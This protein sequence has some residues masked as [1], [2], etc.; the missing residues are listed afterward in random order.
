MT[1]WLPDLTGKSGPLYLQLADAIEEAIAD[2]SLPTGQKLPPQRNLAFDLKVTIGTIGRAYA[3]AH[4]RGLVTG[5]VGRGTYVLEKHDQKNAS[6][7][8]S[9]DGIAGTRVQDAPLDKGRF[10]TTAAPDVGQQVVIEPLIGSVIRDFPHEIVNYT[11]HFP[12]HWLEAGRRWL[13]Q[14]NAPHDGSNI[15]ITNGAHAGAIAVITAFTSPGDRIVFEDL[16]YTQ[17]SRSVRLTGRRIAIAPSDE[18]G[19]IP[20]EFERVCNQQ[21]PTMAFLMPS[22]HNPTLAI[23][24]Y[25]RRR[26]IAAIAAQHNV[27]LIEDD[28]YGVMT[29]SNI[30]KMADIAPERTFLIGSL[31]KSVSAGLR[32]GWVAC[33]P[34]CAQRVRVTHKLMSGGVSFLLAEAAAQLVLSGEAQTL[35]RKCSAEIEWRENLARQVFAGYDFVSSPHV[36][37]LWLKLPEPWLAGTFKAA[38][39]ENG[40][41]ID[42]ED[43]FKAGRVDRTYH[44]VRI[45]FSSPTDRKHVENGFATLR[46]LLENERAGYEGSI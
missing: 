17:V 43:E 33:P 46:Q 15:V 40:L 16:T 7:A 24:P 25:E 38:A 23:M 18:Y 10:D 1:N 19:M 34:H 37:I 41:L 31:S 26:A 27:W 28:T 30:P 14:E 35:L 3:L 32:C 13:N 12:Q 9:S 2:N 44:R 36:P 4:E 29:P 22:V 5:E 20:E 8:Y 21:H 42:D 6:A 39:Y 45:A 11:R